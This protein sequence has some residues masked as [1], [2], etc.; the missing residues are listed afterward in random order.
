MVG[1]VAQNEIRVRRALFP[2]VAVVRYNSAE[3][4]NSNGN[5]SCNF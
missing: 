2:E 4:V 3:T 5:R 1:M